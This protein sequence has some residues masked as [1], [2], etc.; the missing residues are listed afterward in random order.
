MS[1]SARQYHTR[2]PRYVLKT[3]DESLMRFAGMETKGSA[4]HAR[5]RDLSE[6]GVAFTLGAEVTID[7]GDVLK[8]EFTIPGRSQIACFA[9]VIRIDKIQE[10]DP[11]L[12]P[13]ESLLIACKFRSLPTLHARALAGGL[14][15]R[16]QPESESLWESE[17]QRHTLA[18]AALSVSLFFTL[19]LLALPAS[20]WVA[21]VRSLF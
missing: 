18:F 1:A 16:V 17:K 11:D 6:N 5:V 4:T 19:G 3:E 15:N 2:I 20:T 13:R 12:G 14:K 10:W 8:I 21:T 9:T 7:E